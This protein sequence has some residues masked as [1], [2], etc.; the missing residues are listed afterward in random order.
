MPALFMLQRGSALTS[1]D[2]ATSKFYVIDGHE[3][4]LDPAQMENGDWR[5][6]D[7]VLMGDGQFPPFGIFDVEAQDYIL[8]FYQTRAEAE[9]ALL[10]LQHD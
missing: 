4:P 10:V 3:F 1:P 9:A 7:G 8:P 2:P 5:T 6:A